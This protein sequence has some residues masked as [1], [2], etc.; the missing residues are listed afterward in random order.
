ME[1]GKRSGGKQ[2]K[3]DVSP[4]FNKASSKKQINRSID[5]L[6]LETSNLGKVE[7][8]A[9]EKR[10]GKNSKHS[11]NSSTPSSLVVEP[12]VVSID[13][14]LEKTETSSST[15]TVS[16][17]SLPKHLHLQRLKIQKQV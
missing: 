9:G 4:V 13:S 10:V 7:A 12:S 2:V 5:K 17:Q 6:T 8:P 15:N 16:K 11:G 3:A 1:S 14:L